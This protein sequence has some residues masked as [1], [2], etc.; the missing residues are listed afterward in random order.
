MLEHLKTNKKDS[1]V[2]KALQKWQSKRLKMLKYLK[3]TDL[4]KFVGTCKVVG[5]D[6]DSIL[7]L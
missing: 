7:A 1:P 6:P 4:E 5:I 2:K 3:R